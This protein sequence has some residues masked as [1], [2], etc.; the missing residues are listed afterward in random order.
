[1]RATTGWCQMES[2]WASGADR[3]D[4]IGAERL[5]EGVVSKDS[6]LPLRRV[7]NL[8]WRGCRTRCQ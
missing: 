3:E 4:G 5:R 1:V 6:L 8:G 2:S 7:R